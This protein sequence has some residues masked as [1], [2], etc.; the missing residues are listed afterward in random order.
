[1]YC[2][3]C[4]S[5]WRIVNRLVRMSGYGTYVNTFQIPF[6]ELWHIPP[7]SGVQYWVSDVHH[8]GLLPSGMLPS[9]MLPSGLYLRVCAFG[10]VAL[11]YHFRSWSFVTARVIL[12]LESSGHESLFIQYWARANFLMF[13]WYVYSLGIAPSVLVFLSHAI[14][15]RYLVELVLPSWV[16]VICLFGLF[17][18]IHIL[19]LFKLPIVWGLSCYESSFFRWLCYLF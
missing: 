14:C 2:F 10:F 11:L 12:G 3:E 8:Y 5:G 4:E 7:V 16:F 13:H 9:G 17:W 15:S 19:Y 1:M 18:D 6:W